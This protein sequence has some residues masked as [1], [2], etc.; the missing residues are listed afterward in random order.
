V[1]IYDA[2]IKRLRADTRDAKDLAPKMGLPLSTL[3]DIKNGITKDSRFSTLR[4]IAAHYF[5][6]KRA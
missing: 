6:T 4:K 3:K 2:A 5:P 1:D